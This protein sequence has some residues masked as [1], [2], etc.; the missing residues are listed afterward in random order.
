MKEFNL[1]IKMIYK[2]LT[3]GMSSVRILPLI[4]FLGALLA[5][6]APFVHMIY[7]NTKN[8]ELE[9]ARKRYKSK[10]INREEFIQ[11][12]IKATYFGYD[13]T[14]KFWYSIGKPLAMLYFSFLLM[15]ASFYINEKQLKTAIRLGS[16][17]AVLVSSYFITWAF[18]YRADFDK[19]LYFTSI[20]FISILSTITSYILISHRNSIIKKI[21]ILTNHIVLKGK[22]HV[23][24][25]NKENYIRDYIETFNKI[26][27]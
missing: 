12:K 8:V 25:E 23:P 1:L 15:Y 19:N 26:L 13:N 14:R 17:I 4:L 27:D 5:C 7:P 18:W 22:S 20:G 10:E 2:N 21:R 6:T 11:Q 9:Y 24:R 3:T 16:F